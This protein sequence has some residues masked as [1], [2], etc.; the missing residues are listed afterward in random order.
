MKILVG[1]LVLAVT[2]LFGVIGGLKRETNRLDTQITVLKIRVSDLE[3]RNA[4]MWVV[5]PHEVGT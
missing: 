5:P 2:L 3:R 1:V 4:P